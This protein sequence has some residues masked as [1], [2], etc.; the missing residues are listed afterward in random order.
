MEK[1][2]IE[3]W[4]DIEGYE[5]LYQVSNF[6]QVKSLPRTI[7]YKDGRKRIFPE[8]ILKP[9]KNKNDYLIVKI[10]KNDKQESFYIHQL[11]AQMFL[12]NPQN[13]SCVN[14]KDENKQNNHV[15]NLE[16]CSY[17]YNNSYGTKPERLSDSLKIYYKDKKNHP[18]YGKH[19][20]EET[21]QKI[22]EG[23]KGKCITK[24]TR[25]RISESCKGKN[26][27]PILQYTLDGVFIR[28]W[29]SVTTASKE[30]NLNISSIC[31]CCKEKYQSCGGYKWNYKQ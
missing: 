13:Y 4:K 18:M 31:M 22:G 28:E 19:H 20:S 26:N 3:V 29:D 15:D 9:S 7:I 12:K 6:G 1:E 5:G 23:N 24:E 11:V 21:K 17:S 2:Q 14:H 30:L 16:F 8:K 10:S 27:K 25:Q